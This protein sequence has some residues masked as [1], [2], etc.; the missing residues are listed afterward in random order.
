MKINKD[1]Y[2]IT[3]VYHVTSTLVDAA[4]VVVTDLA[5]LNSTNPSSLCEISQTFVLEEPPVLD[6]G[7]YESYY[8]VNDVESSQLEYVFCDP[9]SDAPIQY[10]LDGILNYGIL[11]DDV[12]DYGVSCFGAED[13]H[14]YFT[15]SGGTGTYFYTIGDSDPEALEDIINTDTDDDGNF[16]NCGLP[17]NDVD[18]DGCEED[19]LTCYSLSGLSAGIYNI[20]ISD[21]NGQ[22][23]EDYTDTEGC[24]ESF[25]IEL[26]EPNEITT[27]YTTSDYNGYG[28]SCYG[29]SDGQ[30]SIQVSGGEG[31][32]FL[33]YSY[34]W[35]YLDDTNTEFSGISQNGFIM[36][37]FLLAGSYEVVVTDIRGCSVTEIIEI[38]SPPEPAFVFETQDC[39][40]ISCFVDND[41]D[42]FNDI[43][44]GSILVTEPPSAGDGFSYEWTWTYTVD[45]DGNGIIEDDEIFSET[46][47]NEGSLIDL[48]IG[49][50]EVT[51][52]DNLT[53]CI[54]SW[55]QDDDVWFIS[56]PPP[57][58]L[59]SA[60][61]ILGFE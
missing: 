35:V 46:I 25:V 27:D 19:E 38:I 7:A 6:I 14:I 51:I 9:D 52:T 23:F 44:D 5:S 12:S 2:P 57:R 50:Y 30:F 47:F 55:P 17:C 43:A 29:E 1:P 33:P 40:D 45:L 42:G 58:V 18:G 60:Y 34:S 37:E 20:T 11:I 36:A 56:E 13:G 15:V 26:T 4:T 24:S 21:S 41:Q 61:A 31:E 28:V 39:F 59:P 8:C 54:S 48:S 32:G 10:E 16:I 49:Y 22:L 3:D 53:G